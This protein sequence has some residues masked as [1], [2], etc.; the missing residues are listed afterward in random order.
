[1][2]DIKK[3]LWDFRYLKLKKP[4]GGCDQVCCGLEETRCFRQFAYTI[5]KVLLACGVFDRAVLFW[6]KYSDCYL[7]IAN[8]FWIVLL[9]YS[10]LRCP[11]VSFSLTVPSS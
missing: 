4:P 9:E 6:E 5:W 8:S 3:R 7:P 1:M 11:L 2:E 10:T